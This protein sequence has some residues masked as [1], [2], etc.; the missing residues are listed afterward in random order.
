[1]PPVPDKVVI[2]RGAVQEILFQDNDLLYLR[3]VNYR[4]R[5]QIILHIQPRRNQRQLAVNRHDGE[6]W[7]AERILELPEDTGATLRLRV[8]FTAQ[9]AEI[10]VMRGDDTLAELLFEPCAGLRGIAELER[11][12][13]ILLRLP[14]AAPAAPEQPAPR[15]ALKASLAAGGTL[16][17]Q[18][19]LDDPDGQ[20][21]A[22]RPEQ[23]GWL[24]PPLALLTARETE[25]PA[26]GRPLLAAGDLVGS[27]AKTP[28]RWVSL[29]LADGTTRRLPLPPA[30]PV[31]LETIQHW[32]GLAC[33]APEEIGPVF[34]RLLA[35][36]LLALQ[37]ELAARPLAHRERRFG[38]PLPAPRASLVIPL[39][40]RLDFMAFQAALFSQGGLDQDELI[41][42]L[43]NPAQAEEAEQLARSA[44]ARFGLPL[45]LLLPERRQG[46]GG[47]SNLGLAAARG[48]HVCFL[49]SDAFPLDTGWLDRL[50]A[51]LDADAGIGVVGARLLFANGTLQHDGMWFVPQPGLAGWP[52]PRHLGK[53]LHPPEAAP[54]LLDVPAVTGAC[55]ALRRE[56][57]LELGG[58]DPAYVIG[59]FEDADLCR[60]VLARGLRCCVDRAVRLWHLERQSQGSD[61]EPWRR[62]L[63][64][65][66]AATFAGR[67]QDRIEM[68][69]E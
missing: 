5:G 33:P 68:T 66:N 69:H 30:M 61:A 31:A 19:R 10:G 18:G 12:P 43:D 45:R 57:A 9:G 48:R 42:V 50:V 54:G 11:A 63:S 7:G 36:P 56:V 32:L 37:A 6:S 8:A 4:L 55:M 47:A 17:L 28:P 67:W 3:S 64:L 35:T 65:L 52:F 14:A 59:D 46:F 44:Q 26:P 2:Q 21:L 20:A 22:L 27:A 24:C 34:S 53:G 41:Y 29:A 13:S 25:A 16:L 38:E 40:G 49:N 60:R 23:E 39:Y 51:R 15:L 62:N 1:M 58:F